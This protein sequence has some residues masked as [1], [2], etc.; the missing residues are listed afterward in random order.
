[1][2]NFSLSFLASKM[3]SSSSA[4]L[5]LLTVML[6]AVSALPSPNDTPTVDEEEAKKIKK[7]VKEMMKVINECLKKEGDFNR[8]EGTI[9]GKKI[10]KFLSESKENWEKMDKCM[11]GSELYKQ[12]IEGKCKEKYDAKKFGKNFYKCIMACEEKEEKKA[13]IKSKEEVEVH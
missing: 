7:E 11:Q 5:M 1:M 8:T 6:V 4:I 9:N 13:G 3:V 12:C 10:N 2:Y